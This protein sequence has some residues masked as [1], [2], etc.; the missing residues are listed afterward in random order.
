[1]TTNYG[2]LKLDNNANKKIAFEDSKTNIDYENEVISLSVDI[3]IG[4]SFGETDRFIKVINCRFKTQADVESILADIQAL[5]ETGAPFKL[6][7]QVNSGGGAGDFFAFDGSVR[8]MLVLCEKIRGVSKAPGDE[9][10][11]FIDEI[12]FIEASK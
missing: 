12:L 4:F 7:W 9:T 3:K 11:F 5:Q 10:I 6:E 8:S 1:M 2:W